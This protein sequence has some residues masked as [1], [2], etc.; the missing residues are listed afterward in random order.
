MLHYIVS[1]SA[2]DHS[3]FT[4]NSR[5]GFPEYQN[6]FFAPMY[7][8]ASAVALSAGSLLDPDPGLLLNAYQL[9]WAFS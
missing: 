2:I 4:P 3:L 8:L 9:G 1:A 7:D 6:L 5:L